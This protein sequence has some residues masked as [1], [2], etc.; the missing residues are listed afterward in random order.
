MSAMRYD[1][2]ACNTVGV[3]AVLREALCQTRGRCPF[4]K[5]KEQVAM[6]RERARRAAIAAGY[7]PTGG[8]R[9][10]PKNYGEGRPDA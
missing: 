8:D 5:T 7:Y 3:C 2:F 4:F 10:T 1:C 9:Y 6:D